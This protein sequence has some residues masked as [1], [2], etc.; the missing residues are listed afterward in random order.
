MDTILFTL[1]LKNKRQA[2]RVRAATRQ[3]A[4]FIG[5]APRDQICLSAAAFD[6]ARQALD[7][8]GV[9]TARFHLAGDCFQIACTPTRQDGTESTPLRLSKRLPGVAAVPLEDLPWMLQQ[10]TEIA[11]ADPFEELCRANQ[12][13]LQALLDLAKAQPGE[14]DLLPKREPSAA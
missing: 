2:V 11:P 12:E 7:L 9:A 14:V 13:L 5:F 4:A 8:A 1:T 10:L 6:L 3:A